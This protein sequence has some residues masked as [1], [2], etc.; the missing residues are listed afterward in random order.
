MLDNGS[1]N[2]CAA[3]APRQVTIEF[4]CPKAGASGPL[5]PQN[6]TASNLP[7]TCAYKIEFA[8]CAACQPPCPPP[9]PPPG[10]PPC[11]TPPCQARSEYPQYKEQCISVPNR[12]QCTNLDPSIGFG[13]TCEWTCGVCDALEADIKY[14]DFCYEHNTSATCQNVNATCEWIPSN[15]TTTGSRETK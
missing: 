6:W 11:Q 9:P 1:N 3:G 2:L 5:V 15:A 14:Q 10:P 7:G 8:T 13:K 4:M 12:T